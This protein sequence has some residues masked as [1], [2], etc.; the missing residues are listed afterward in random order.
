[1]QAGYGGL[2]QSTLAYFGSNS[3][4]NWVKRTDPRLRT[5]WI[6][7]LLHAV[8]TT[9]PALTANRAGLVKA[10]LVPLPALRLGW[11][12]TFNKQNDPSYS[13]IL[14]SNRRVLFLS[15]FKITATAYTAKPG[16]KTTK[17]SILTVQ[18]IVFFINKHSLY[19][20][21][22]EDENQKQTQ[23][24]QYSWL[25]SICF[26]SILPFELRIWSHNWK[27]FR[28]NTCE[29]VSLFKWKRTFFFFPPKEAAT[30][31]MFVKHSLLLKKNTTGVWYFQS[32][33]RYQMVTHTVMQNSTV[34]TKK[35]KLAGIL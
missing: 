26:L 22:S 35:K 3:N 5:E 24:N 25:E 30:S 34:L 13:V 10:R 27:A 4:E 21:V 28:E 9:L 29:R 7:Q 31:D 32:Y 1:M 19:Y 2:D 14:N 6:C 12:P 18:K 33:S 20:T 11:S 23:E 17:K 15:L 16:R 8:T